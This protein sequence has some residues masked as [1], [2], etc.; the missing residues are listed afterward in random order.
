MCLYIK[1]SRYNGV[2]TTT[3]DYYVYK[4]LEKVSSIKYR[5]PVMGY[6]CYNTDNTYIHVAK[7]FDANRSG[8]GTIV[9][10]GFHAYRTKRTAIRCSFAYETVVRCIIPA[11]SLVYYGDINDVCSNKLIVPINAEVPRGGYWQ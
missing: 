6:Y 3:K 10:R 5:S 8:Y 9:D 1:N 2:C 4:R 11:G 7:G